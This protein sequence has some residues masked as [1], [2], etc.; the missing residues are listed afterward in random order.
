[1]T[2]ADG[3]AVLP[4]LVPGLKYYVEFAV[5]GRW[6]S[7]SRPFPVAPGETVRLPDMVIDKDGAAGHGGSSP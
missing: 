3:I 7:R 5:D 1:M 2:D 4:A 6:V